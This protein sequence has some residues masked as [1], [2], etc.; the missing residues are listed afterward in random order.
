MLDHRE[1]IVSLAKENG[2]QTGVELGLG[3]GLLHR[4]LLRECPS[5]SMVGVD[6]GA[7]YERRQLQSAIQDAYRD[8]CQILHYTTKAAALFVADEW[9]DFIFIDAG[10]G[11]SAVRDDIRLWRPK[12]KPGGW[13]GGHDYHELHP[14]VVRAVDEAF[15]VAFKVLEH[16]VWV[17][18]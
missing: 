3:S 11:Y 13:F 18:I 2:W 16:A 8:R 14:G 10:H 6:L 1:L 12:L 5:L 17:A 7:H 9:A 15:G 4:R